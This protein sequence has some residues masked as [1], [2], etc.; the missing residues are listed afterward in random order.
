MKM[1]M[2]LT[3]DGLIRA[4]RMKGHELG[5]DHDRVDRLA[6]LRNGEALMLLA[7]EAR[8]VSLEAGDEFGR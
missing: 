6:V 8:R 2:Q 7:Q 1:A 5:D 3:L 4:L